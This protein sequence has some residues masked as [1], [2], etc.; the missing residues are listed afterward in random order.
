MSDRIKV[1]IVTGTMGSGKTTVVAEASD[2]LAQADVFHAAIDMDALGTGFLEQGLML[3]LPFRNL[4]SL[5]W[6]Y[7]AAGARHLL[8]ADAMESQ[9][10]FNRIR[11]A[12]LDA[13]FV[14][15][16]LRVDVATA[17]ARLRSREPGMF[18][19]RFVAWAEA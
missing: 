11:E 8:L 10:V 18:Q 3:D 9:A 1:I 7:R 5:W 6:N 17:Q 15:C 16:R 12:I 13:E 4:T 19:E 14:V 2:L